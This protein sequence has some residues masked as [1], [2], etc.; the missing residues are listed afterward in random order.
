[1][2]LIKFMTQTIKFK[3]SPEIKQPYNKKRLLN[4]GTIRYVAFNFSSTV[5]RQFLNRLDLH[6]VHTTTLINMEI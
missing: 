2:K 1:M 6:V 3:K 5:S 4:F